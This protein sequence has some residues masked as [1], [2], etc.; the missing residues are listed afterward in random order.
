V[1][2]LLMIDLKNRRMQ[3]Y[4]WP[5]FKVVR[6]IAVG[7]HVDPDLKAPLQWTRSPSGLVVRCSGANYKKKEKKG[8]EKREEKKGK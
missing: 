2:G 4:D 7:N 6:W 5:I 3:R 8:K 1:T